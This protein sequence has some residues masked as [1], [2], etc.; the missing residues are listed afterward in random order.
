MIDDRDGYTPTPVLSHAIIRHNATRGTSQG[1]ADGIVITPSH[2][3][4]ADGGFKYNPPHGG[5]ADTSVTKWIEDR[6]NALLEDGWEK[7]PRH[8]VPARLPP[9]EHDELRLH[10]ELRRRPA[11]GRR[12]GRDRRDAGVRIGADPMGG[13]S[14]DYW[15]AIAERLGLDIDVVNP[16]VDPTFSFMP[17]DW[18]GKIRMDCSSPFSMANLVSN[19]TPTIWPRAMT[20][21]PTAT[22]SSPPTRG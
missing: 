5:P 15:V 8:T 14:V 10:G 2:N 18:D 7:I 1:L 21:T 12:R 9:G 6:A 20:R 3:P 22:A 4:P 17:L 11:P 16:E 19:R 13:A